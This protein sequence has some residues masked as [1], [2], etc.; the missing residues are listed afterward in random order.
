[1][2][3]PLSLTAI[4]GALGAVGAGMAN[5]AG[6]QAWESAGGL[7]RRIAGRE[8]P[9][10]AGPGDLDAIARTVHDGVRSDP[11]YARAWLALARGVPDSAARVPHPRPE[12]P[13]STR[14]FTDRDKAM[15]ELDREAS[16]RADGRPRVALLHGGPGMGTS[17]LAVHWGCREAARFS[18]GQLYVDL[19][20]T[21]TGGAL[22]AGTALRSLLRQLGVPDPEVP[23]SV[24]ERIRAF[25]GLVADRRILVV[26]DHAHSAAQVRPLIPAAS[27]AF[28]LVVAAGPLAGLDAL[29]VRVAPLKD[30]DARLLLTDL[31]G[32]EA[33]SEAE[34]ALPALLAR[35]GGSPFALRAAAPELTAPVPPA[36]R[37][38]EAPAVSAPPP[39][40]PVRAVA[41]SAYRTLTP[42]AARV[43]RLMSLRPWPAFGPAAASWATGLTEG[44][45]AALLGELAAA[46]LLESAES[47][48]FF[49]RPAVRAHAE[50]AAV[51]EDRVAGCSAAVT[52]VVAGY[53]RFTLDAAHAVLPQS[54]RVPPRPEN[55]APTSA[56]APAPAPYAR[57]ADAVA[58]LVAERGNLVQAVHAAEEFG[59]AETVVLLAQALWPLQLKAGHHDELLPAL[60]LAA[61]TADDRFPR[62]RAAGAL[63]AQVAHSLTELAR[64]DEAEEEA[65]AAAESERAAGHA[66]GHASAV[67][68]LGLLRLRQWRFSEAYTCFE[69]SGRLYDAIGPDDE[70]AGDLPRARA[71]LERHRGR[72]LR[73][74]GR[75]EEAGALLRG[76]LRFFREVGDDYNAAKTL[77]DLADTVLGTDDTA[78]ALPLIDEASAL[79]T[80]EGGHYHLVYLRALRERC[81]S[82]PP[83]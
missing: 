80:E 5:E 70:G 26:L 56:L 44:T 76:A 23:P 30:R 50:E 9:A 67:E 35:C 58:A 19:R 8:V 68:F 49:H 51:R 37:P 79:L 18:D 59:D 66:R 82:P 61:R 46:H 63:H 10:P 13:S 81:V 22:D 24:E 54:W 27:G 32:K 75:F 15:K 7:V 39:D 65:R 38:P 74:L 69:E 64:W 60:R 71:L 31:V 6:K 3:D 72:A 83:A 21:S 62:S 12:F 1:M 2:L 57:P 73:G 45:A 4:T 78:T 20:G 16:R 33:V 42:D 28:L 17:A 14:F 52:R 40:D 55:P 53:L 48:R 34:A 29:P 36:R 77:T 47:G 43:Y 41:E 11:A 25:R